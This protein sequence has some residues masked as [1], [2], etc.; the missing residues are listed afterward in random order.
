MQYIDIGVN[1]F[2]KQFRKIETL[3][4]SQARLNE[5]GIIITGSSIPSSIQADAYTK[6]NRDVYCT[7]GVHPHDAKSCDEYTI[8]T[9][10]ELAK[11]NPNVVAIGEC[12]LDYDRMFSRKEVQLHWFEEQI[13][14]AKELNLPLFLHEREASHDFFEVLKKYPQQA[15]RAVVHCYTGNR[16][17]AE[18]YLKLGCM[19]G[20]T[21][22]INDTRRNQ[23]LLEAL[24]SIPMDRIMVETDAPYLLPRGVKGLKNPNVPVNVEYVVET[25]ALV[26]GIKKEECRKQVLENTLAFFHL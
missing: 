1:L 5:V 10:R 26:K 17:T 16:E 12:G 13:K 15:Q 9:L 20:V 25:L 22:W 6:E 8:G 3:V 24:Q 19:F 4:V 21:G 14:L 2:S 7:V 11:G 18:K 23:D